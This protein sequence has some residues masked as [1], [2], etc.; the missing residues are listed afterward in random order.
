[1]NCL[2]GA[3]TAP[4]FPVEVGLNPIRHQRRPLVLRVIADI[5]QRK[6]IEHLKDEFVCHVS[7]ELRTPLTSISGSLGLLVG[8]RPGAA[9]PCVPPATIAHKNSQRLVR[10]INDILDVEK[11]GVRTSRLQFIV[12]GRFAAACRAGDRGRPRL[13]RQ[14]GVQ[15][16]LDASRRRSG[17]ARADP[18]RL[19]QVVT[20]LLS[21]AIKF[22]P[23][24]G[25]CRFPPRM[26]AMPSA[27]RC[28]ITVPGSRPV[29]RRASSRNSPRRTASNSRAK[30]RHRPRPE[31]REANR[32]EARARRLR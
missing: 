1:M 22:S 28:A 18:D 10:L 9:R 31:Y 32:R 6:H 11:I 7:H 21:N 27:L 12:Q 23:S 25:R 4:N 8:N 14:L 26:K 16:R 5:S 24:G 2:D 3:R 13:R 15:L 30:E 19:A 29:S 20:N 17:Q